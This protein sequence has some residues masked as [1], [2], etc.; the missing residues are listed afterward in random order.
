[1]STEPTN[2]L[3]KSP[4]ANQLTHRSFF[5]TTENTKLT[6]S[7]FIEL[8]IQAVL[9]RNAVTYDVF[10]AVTNLDWADFTLSPRS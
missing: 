8:I 3:I 5:M 1:M 7:D 4:E 10:Q 2:T 9:L 6:E